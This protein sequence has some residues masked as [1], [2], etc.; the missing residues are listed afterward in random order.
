[1]TSFIY[2]IY[3]LTLIIKY[4]D[5][6]HLPKIPHDENIN[7]SSDGS[8]I[9][10]TTMTQAAWTQLPM[11]LLTIICNLHGQNQKEGPAPLLPTLSHKCGGRLCQKFPDNN[12]LNF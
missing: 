12:A 1:M 4:K 7:I 3:Y 5:M 6:N 2:F 9:F 10:W 8:P 11:D